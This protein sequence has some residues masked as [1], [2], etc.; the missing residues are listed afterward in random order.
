MIQEYCE[1]KKIQ[2]LGQF[3]RYA[4]IDVF[5]ITLVKRNV[6]KLGDA[7]YLWKKS[8]MS[9]SQKVSDLFFVNV[10]SVVD[11]RDVREG[12]AKTFITS[13]GLKGWVE[14]NSWPLTRKHKGKVFKSPFIVIKRTSRMGDSHR[15]IATIINLSD[16]VFVDNHLIVL[17]PKSGKLD[18][19]KDLL[20]RLKTDEMDIWLNNEIRC[21][22]LTVK[23]VSEMPI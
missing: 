14:I 16:D 4:D 13:K 19:C 17:K 3:D 8:L 6:V 22:H 18:D 2:L 10:G 7:D 9:T 23:I 5:A 1:I 11:N 15:A 12:P 20:V 21:R